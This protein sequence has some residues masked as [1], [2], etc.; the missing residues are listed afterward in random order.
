[1]KKR[2]ICSAMAVLLLIL[3][4]SAIAA[5]PQPLAVPS[6]HT[7]YIDGVSVGL[8]AYNIEGRNYF[9]L[10]DVAYVL[11]NTSAMFEVAWN[12]QRGEIALTK[13]VRYSVEG[14]EMAE[15]ATEAVP[16]APSTAIVTVNE[17]RVSLSAYNIGGHNYF[18]LRDLG[19]ALGFHVNWDSEMNAIQVSTPPEN[20]EQPQP[21]PTPTTPEP[22]PT[23]PEPTPT[24][25]EP[26]PSPTPPPT[27]NAQTTGGF[28]PITATEWNAGVGVGWNLGNTFDAHSNRGIGGGWSWLGGGSYANTTARQMEAAWQSGTAVSKDLIDAVAAAGFNAIRI[29]VT[30]HTAMDSDYKIRDDWFA[31][32]KEVVDYAVANDMYIVLNSHHDEVF[33]F[34]LADSDINE[35]KQAI[36]TVWQQIANE[37]KGY[38]EKLAFQAM[39]EP[40]T[41]GS[42]TEWSGG[43]PEERNNVNI[44]NQVFVDTIRAT[45]GNNAERVLIIPGYAASNSNSSMRA[46]VV[47]TDTV[48]D[49]IIVSI[50]SY[51]PN[52]FALSTERNATPVF[53][54]NS[55]SETQQITNP[56]DTAQELFISKGIPV[57]FTEIGAIFRNNNPARV[58]WSEF[59]IREATKRG[60]S[61]FWWDNGPSEAITASS[62]ERFGL[63]NR[64]TAELVHRDVVAALLKGLT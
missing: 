44:L 11:R 48:Q 27:S 55:A 8:R 12:A 28:K 30:W 34:P 13:G 23:T 54:V 59:I 56:F 1:M 51:A 61:C 40:R 35:A 50:H 58:E 10:R 47:P 3:P 16:A 4:L 2:I 31:R 49:R 22:T 36:A 24:A 45:G 14:G 32:V 7:V 60:I 63:F 43:T 38:N 17:S 25:P 18:M 15:A 20:A 9:M 62:G 41:R 26:T 39:N 37:F 21:T 6:A 57:A 64:R 19:D 29:P 5:E 46:I 33:I 53:N 42:R 52:R